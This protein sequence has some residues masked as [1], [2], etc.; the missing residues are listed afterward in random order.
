MKPFSFTGSE[1][2]AFYA[3]VSLAKRAAATVTET[4]APLTA[5]D[6]DI[7]ADNLTVIMRDIDD[8]QY[9]AENI[10]DDLRAAKS[11]LRQ[12]VQRYFLGGGR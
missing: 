11:T 1:H 8:L 7:S 2:E 12:A 9:V 6:A 10:C 3:A 4:L 5:P